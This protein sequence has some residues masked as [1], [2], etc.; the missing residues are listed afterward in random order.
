MDRVI[1]EVVR[2]QRVTQS[3]GSRLVLWGSL[4]GAAAAVAVAFL[5]LGGPTVGS[6]DQAQDITPDQLLAD[7]RQLARSLNERLQNDVAPLANSLAQE[8]PL[9]QEIGAVYSDA[10]SALQFLAMNFLPASADR[11]GAPAPTPS[12]SG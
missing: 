10:Q 5:F 11:D 7:S 8:N 3:S 6:R 2:E 12:Q 1:A 9:Q 4:A